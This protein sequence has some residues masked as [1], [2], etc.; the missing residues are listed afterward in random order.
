[1]AVREGARYSSEDI[2]RAVF[3]RTHAARSAA[4]LK[5]GIA[6]LMQKKHARR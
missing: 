6:R 4:E 3:T 5:E 2:H 1:M